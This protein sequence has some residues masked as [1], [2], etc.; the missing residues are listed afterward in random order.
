[1]RPH[2]RLQLWRHQP[3]SRY[4][5]PRIEEVFPAASYQY[6]LFGMGF[7]TDY[8]DGRRRSDRPDLADAYFA[9][10]Q[11]LTR[12]MLAGLPG[13]RELIAHI[14]RHGLARR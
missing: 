13:N 10:A 8:G 12:K 4:D 3:P 2:L 5:L 7:E 11:E 6:I 1:M 9:E 14:Q